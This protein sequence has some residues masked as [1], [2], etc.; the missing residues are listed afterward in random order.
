MTTTEVV[1]V[2]VDVATARPPRVHAR[3]YTTLVV[4]RR[5][6]TNVQVDAEFIAAHMAMCHPHVV[7]VLG[8]R[9]IDWEE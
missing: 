7:M 4:E 5:D 2:E 9:V 6:R 1:T 3:M 8:M